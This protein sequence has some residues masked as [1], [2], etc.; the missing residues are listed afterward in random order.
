MYKCVRLHVG[1]PDIPYRAAARAPTVPPACLFATV[2][3]L[4]AS[5]PAAS[6][7]DPADASVLLAADGALFSY[8]FLLRMYSIGIAAFVVLFYTHR[9]EGSDSLCALSSP[10]SPRRNPPPPSTPPSNPPISPHP[11]QLLARVCPIFPCNCFCGGRSTQVRPSRARF[12]PRLLAK[13]W[14]A[15]DASCRRQQQQIAAQA[16]VAKQQ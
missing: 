12:L 13:R 7:A 4:M 5:Q 9:E 10:S 6:D 3:F 11:P 16:K 15:C 2:R 14:Q 1:N 8:K